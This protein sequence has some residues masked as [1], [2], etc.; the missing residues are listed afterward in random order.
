MFDQDNVTRPS[1]SS[2]IGSTD[3]SEAFKKLYYHLYTNSNSSRAER[4]I[5]DL[6]K[7]LLVKIISDDFKAQGV[8]DRFLSGA[9]TAN[10]SLYPLLK[11]KFPQLLDVSDTFS[12]DDA[13]LKLGYEVIQEINLLDAPSHVVGDAFQALMGPRLRGDKGQFFTPKTVVRAMVRIV[14]PKSGDVVVDPACGTG[15][16]LTE[17]ALYWKD[18]E[19]SPGT[20][21]GADKDGDLSLLASAMLG[22][23]T[24]ARYSIGHVNSL[25][26]TLP[27]NPLGGFIG[28][29]DCV[30]TNPPFGTKI[31]VTE[32]AILRQYELGYVWRFDSSEERWTKTDKLEAS[33]DPQVL[34]VDLCVKLLKPGAKMAIV[35]PEG[36]FGNKTSGF[37][38]DYLRQKGTIY[39]LIDCPRTTF[40]PGTDTKTNILFFKKSEAD[41]PGASARTPEVM[42]IGVALNCGHDRRGRLKK[43]SGEA[44][45]DDFA[46][47]AQD[48]RARV[49]DMWSVSEI[50]NPYYLV[51][52]YYDKK[53][54]L[55]LQQEAQRFDADII[56]LGEMV[57][58]GWI[59]IEKGDEVGAEAYGTGD[60]PFVRTSDIANFE[61][62]TDPTRGVAEEIYQKYA[63]SQNLRPGNILMVVD[64]RYRIG[65]CAIL[66]EANYRCIAQSHLRIIK[67]NENTPFTSL[68]LLLLLNLPSVQREIRSLVYIQAT[69][70]ALGKRIFEIKIPLPRSSSNW[71][72]QVEEFSTLI[73]TRATSLHLLQKFEPAL[74]EL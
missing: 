58:R 2:R 71:T 57:E 54:Q 72:N 67:V 8:I 11:Q 55:L 13:A 39:A 51:P 35:L 42:E 47:L 45:P 9:L 40:Q 22:L 63:S 7:L 48:Y 31:P 62:S 34:F 50:T 53:N 28:K 3:P 30:L 68:E 46:T 41:T 12:L 64:G 52:R 44:Y 24:R 21:V 56:P 66:H 25:D 14:E 27:T 38:L 37:V 73:Q 17:T 65:R 20:L 33:Q 23:V 26:L 4:I 10:Q 19:T 36:M 1:Y 32:P 6:S 29:A 15:G 16:F 69:L 18:N 49:S 43:S 60:Y 61:I 59:S 5:S 70:G 74:P